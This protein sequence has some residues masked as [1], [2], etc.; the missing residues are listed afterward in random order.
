MIV[1][2][3]RDKAVDLTSCLEDTLLIEILSVMV[4]SA[5]AGWDLARVTV[6]K[7]KSVEIIN[8]L[9][10]L[11]YSTLEQVD[12][13]NEKSILW[14]SLPQEQGEGGMQRICKLPDVEQKTLVAADSPPVT[15]L[16]CEVLSVE[17]AAERV[18]EARGPIV[19]SDEPLPFGETGT[20]RPAMKHKMRLAEWLRELAAARNAI[21]RARSALADAYRVGP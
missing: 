18:A 12:L 14:I 1:P 11:G 19:I 13:K 4:R 5:C 16:R 21:Y 9:L 20:N 8:L 3:A 7:A 10:Q 15:Q 17:Q 6:P 2:E